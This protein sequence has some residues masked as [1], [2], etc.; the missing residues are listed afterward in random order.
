VQ[1]RCTV[2]NANGMTKINIFWLTVLL[3]SGVFLA[4]CRKYEE[5][6]PEPE[7]GF[8]NFILLINPETGISEKGILSITYRDGDG[9]I[10]LDQG[11]TLFPFQPDG[12]YYYNLR[13]TLF[14]QQNGTLIERPF[15]FNGRIPP[16][17]PKDQKKAI[18]GIIEYEIDI[19]DPTSTFDTI[20][21]QVRLIDRALNLS[22][23]IATPLIIRI[24]PPDTL[25][26]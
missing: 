15:N 6:P 13:V 3:L 7:I 22:N 5:Y 1:Q 10:G 14:E 11:D 23:E 12:D 18:K 17:I 8:N 19:Y 9:D 24:I 26:L 2:A 21:F 25:A 16:L 4:G 20:Q